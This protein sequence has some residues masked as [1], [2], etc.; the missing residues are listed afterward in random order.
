MD[1]IAHTSIIEAIEEIASVN[2]RTA[3]RDHYTVNCRRLYYKIS[4]DTTPT[5]LKTIGSK[6]NRDHSTVVH[7]LKGADE[8]IKDPRYKQIYIN[9]LNKLGLKKEKVNIFA[10]INDED[11]GID[12][13]TIK[14]IV[15]IIKPLPS[16]K[17]KEL[18]EYRI[19]PF[20][21]MN[22][23]STEQHR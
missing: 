6:V 7:G 16:S 9:V 17:I 4:M 14:E 11:A 18:F 22:K 13:D 15:E 10:E 12:Y 8:L 20:V 5:T 21:R 3:A 19:K 23:L 1:K 2:I